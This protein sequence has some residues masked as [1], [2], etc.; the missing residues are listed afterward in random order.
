MTPEV[1]GF[2]PCSLEDMYKHVEVVDRHHV[3]SK[4]KVQVQIKMCDNN[5]DPFI[6]TLH[7]IILTPYLCYGLFSIITLI[8]SV[9]TCLLHEGFCTVYLGEKEKNVVTLTHSA[10]S[11]HIYLG[12]IK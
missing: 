2:I 12:E 4:Q 3:T 5:G 1:L 7:N 11:K 10:Q 6:A 8:N 9:H